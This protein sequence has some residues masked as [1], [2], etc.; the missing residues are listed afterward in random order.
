MNVTSAYKVGR[1][2]PPEDS[3]F[4]PGQSG[5]P[6]GR[7]KGHRN[8]RTMFTAILNEKIRMR[9]GDKVRRVTKMEALQRGTIG[10]A[11]KGDL[12][13]ADFVMA[14]AE[15][16]GSFDAPPIKTILEVEYVKPKKQEDSDE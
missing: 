16:Y 3:R 12:K 14:R 13:A 6:K 10:Q 4:Q 9:E 8:A 1:G 2:R 5:N 15:E 7:P 11:L